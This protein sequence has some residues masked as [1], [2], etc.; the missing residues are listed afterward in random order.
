MTG[1]LNDVE[2]HWAWLAIGLFL[3]AA[4]MAIPG[5]FLIWLAGAAIVTGLTAMILPIGLP[6][7]IVLF[8]AL[9]VVA[10]FLGRRYLQANPIEEADPNMNHRTARLVGEVAVVTQAIGNGSGRVKYGDSEWLAK[11]A[12]AARGAHVRITGSD[13]AVLLVEPVIA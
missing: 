13:G 5:V 6:V 8:A 4:E 9:A 3:A 11:G 7:Q 1:W 2:P 10:V 12:D